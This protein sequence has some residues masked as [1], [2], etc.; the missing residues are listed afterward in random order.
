LYNLVLKTLFNPGF[1][2]QLK[3]LAWSLPFL[4][5]DFQ[6]IIIPKWKTG[7]EK[8]LAL[9]QVITKEWDCTICADVTPWQHIG[10]FESQ[11]ASS[12]IYLLG[13]P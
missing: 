8:T 11:A 13:D 2:L 1:E 5:I 3:K 12:T 4:I 6:M 7:I 10:D 9:G